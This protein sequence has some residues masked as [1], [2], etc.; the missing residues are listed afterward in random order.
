MAAAKWSLTLQTLLQCQML[1]GGTE[2]SLCAE[3]WQN[4]GSLFIPV[5]WGNKISCWFSER[6]ALSADNLPQCEVEVL[7]WHECLYSPPPAWC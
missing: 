6:P 1:S 4:S 7:W 5:L 2:M 3:Q